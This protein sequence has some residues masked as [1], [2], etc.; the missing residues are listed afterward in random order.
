MYFFILKAK[1]FWSCNT[2]KWEW[3][4]NEYHVF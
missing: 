4:W 2:I 3:L 1:T